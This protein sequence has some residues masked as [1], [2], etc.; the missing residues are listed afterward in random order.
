MLGRLR[1]ALQRR[2]AAVVEAEALVWCRGARGV[3]MARHAAKNPHQRPEHRRH[4]RMVLRIAKRRLAQ[5][6]GLDTAT[7]YAI[8]D[9]W[10]Q[11]PGSLIR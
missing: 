3:A 10:V 2:Q 4:W 8:G 7:M 6:D 11:R 1:D 5:L 9:T